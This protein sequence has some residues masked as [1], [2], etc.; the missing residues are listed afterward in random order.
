MG[1]SPPP[2][3]VTSAETPHPP[4]PLPNGQFAKVGEV[5]RAMPLAAASADHETRPEDCTPQQ[6]SRGLRL[7]NILRQTFC[8]IP[9]AA[10]ILSA[11]AE[12]SPN[13]AVSGFEARRRLNAEFCVRTR[14][15]AMHFRSQV[16]SKSFKVSTVAE[17]VN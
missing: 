12:R 13:L 8:S 16:M 15:E 9:K 5:P 4:V 2:P 1:T 11:H 10:I 6:I 14:S 7:L 3:S 17:L